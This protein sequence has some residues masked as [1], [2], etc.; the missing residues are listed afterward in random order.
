MTNKEKQL[1]QRRKAITV[2]SLEFW[3]PQERDKALQ[4]IDQ[5]LEAIRKETTDK[6]AHD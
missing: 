4:E 5:E 1:L 3:S 2:G 6:T